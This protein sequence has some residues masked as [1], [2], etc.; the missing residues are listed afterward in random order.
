MAAARTCSSTPPRLSVP[1]CG[2]WSKAKKVSFDSE[3][4]R[5][6]GKT[7]VANISAG[8]FV[9]NFSRARVRVA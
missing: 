6:S 8:K 1:E 9:N 3:E 7:A 5:R 2:A 4:D